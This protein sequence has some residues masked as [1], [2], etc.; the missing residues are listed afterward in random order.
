MTKFESSASPVDA[1]HDINPLLLRIIRSVLIFRIPLSNK[2]YLVGYLTLWPVAVCT[3][4]DVYQL[5]KRA[6]IKAVKVPIRN[7]RVKFG[8]TDRP[9]VTLAVIIGL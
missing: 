4:P 2:M 5:V 7:V 8:I 6:V 3:R 9:K 1:P